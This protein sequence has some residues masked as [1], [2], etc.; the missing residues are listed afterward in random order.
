MQF[1][2]PFKSFDDF[3]KTATGFEEP[4]PFQRKLA[5]ADNLPRILDVPT[6]LGKTAAVV[7][8]WLWRRWFDERFRQKTPRR[9]VYCLPMRVLVE[10]TY[11]NAVHWLNNLNI[12]GGQIAENGSYD[13]CA[14]KDDPDKVHV[15]MLLGGE[16]DRDWD[17]YPERN[18][19]LIGTQDM[20]L[21]RALNRGYAMSRFR[22]PVQFG[23]LNNDAL[24]V[25]DEV[26]LMGNGLATTAQLQAFRR[27]LGTASPVQSCWMSATMRPE[28]L[29]T[30]DFTE[31]DAPE[32]LKLGAAD[33]DFEDVRQRLTASKPIK[34]ASSAAS[35]DG[36]SEAELIASSHKPGSLTLAVVNTV[37]RATAIYS[38]LRKDKKLAA[39]L[40]LL[41]S[42]FRLPD[43]KAAL[44]RLLAE[45][46]EAGTIAVS[47]QVVEAGVDVSA[48][49]LF[50]DLAPWPSLIQRFGRCNRRGEFDDAGVIWFDI[51]LDKKGASAPYSD[52][53]LKHAR[54]KLI[55]L[56][57]ASP[58]N[59]PDTDTEISFNH[60]LRRRD[61][62]DLFDTTPDLAGADIDVSRF[63][64]EA[65]EHH[66]QVFWRNIDD[67]PG[68]DEPAP[69]KDELCSVSIA[70]LN[71]VKDL[72]KWRWDH[73]EKS[74]IRP[75][76]VYPGLV[77][78][79]CARDGCYSAETGF[80]GSK[81][82]VPEVLIGAVA[83]EEHND[84]DRHAETY[85]Q[86]LP[87]HTDAVVEV[88]D[89][90]ITVY[91][92]DLATDWKEA[93]R[94]AARWHDAGK[95]HPVFQKAMLGD[96]PEK[97]ASVVWAKTAR[98]GT[99]YERRGF[100][101]ELASALVMFAQEIPD[102]AAYL[103]AAHHGKV[104][105]SI[106]SLPH[107]TGD[108]ENPSRRY[109]RGIW[110]GDELQTADLGGG[111][112]LPVAKLDLSSMELGEGPH[113][114]SWLARMLALRN[115]PALGPFRLSF[116]EA[117]LRVADWR[118][119]RQEEVSRG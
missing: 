105:L 57:D 71:K 39:D 24:W 95:A 65:D 52:D 13:P 18:A 17:V 115:S 46:G 89:K 40:V 38:V 74:W 20:L 63:I 47:T 92:D 79:L 41:H 37:N 23:L 53:E 49:M 113:G 80:T 11:G 66:V 78:M 22:W 97:D 15:H 1:E 102:L 56:E 28:W 87:D 76:A 67:K 19:I 117:L 70:D 75:T 108:N 12:L 45:P 62:I 54:V 69:R 77:L 42:R 114:P 98:R 93:L 26:Q 106:R 88:I 33:M 109:A 119:S 81:K 32:S 99:V 48:K 9:L 112:T 58:S 36:K 64:R 60:V 44:M 103:A 68:P 116:L 91:E 96:P 104:R 29:Q 73:L 5:T 10:Q 111:V 83:L 110:Q 85:W 94:I 61:I 59:L 84:D 16:V 100:R 43:R 51:D 21:S 27:M 118:A 101:H 107:E 2:N 72:P 3:F 34:A 25:M 50:T 6:G 86:S 90:L 8:A 82:D 7:L 30:V 35:K 55:D 4:Y 31:N 14:G